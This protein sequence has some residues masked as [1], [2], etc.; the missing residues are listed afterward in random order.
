MD[1]MVVKA[2]PGRT[3]RRHDP[4]FKA[5]VIAACLHP[6]VSVASVALANGLNA[7]MLRKWVK[8]HGE[9][10]GGDIPRRKESEAGRSVLVAATVEAPGE[11]MEIRLDVRRGGTTI[12]MAWPVSALAGLGRCLREVLG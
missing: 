2:V 3:R 5:Q 10:G 6:G 1:T 8:A 11:A 4:D 9:E 7:N 12:Q